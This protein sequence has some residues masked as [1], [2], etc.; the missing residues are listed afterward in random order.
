M[1]QSKQNALGKLDATDD[2]IEALKI[3]NAY[4]QKTY[5]KE[6]IL[7]R[8]WKQT[9]GWTKNNDYLLHELC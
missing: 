1:I 3:A 6:Y 7:N 2:E 8:Q 5:Q 9:F 4:E